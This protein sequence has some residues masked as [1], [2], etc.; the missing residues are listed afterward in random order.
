MKD[1]FFFRT[2]M[3]LI[4]MKIKICISL[5]N[6]IYLYYSWRLYHVSVV[7][8]RYVDRRNIY[9]VHDVIFLRQC[10]TVRYYIIIFIVIIIII[11]IFFLENPRLLIK[12]TFI[13]RLRRRGYTSWW[14]CVCVVLWVIDQIWARKRR[15]YIIPVDYTPLY[16]REWLKKTHT[17]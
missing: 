9:C 15:I 2:Y 4:N 1:H 13:T 10:I 14:V 16:H 7:L 11:V 12:I 17:H 6:L 8:C 3:S 5:Y